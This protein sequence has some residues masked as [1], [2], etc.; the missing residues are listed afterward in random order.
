MAR[1]AVGTEPPVPR[2]TSERSIAAYGIHDPSPS[3]DDRLRWRRGAREGSAGTIGRGASATA[4]GCR[5]VPRLP[6]APRERESAPWGCHA[7]RAREADHAELEAARFAARTAGGS[8]GEVTH[9][10]HPR[11]RAVAGGRL[12]CTWTV[13]F[14]SGCLSSFVRC[15]PPRLLV[16]GASVTWWRQRIAPRCPGLSQCI[17][18][19]GPVLTTR[20]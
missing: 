12:R 14:R 15:P 5:S 17:P 20:L 2:N 4:Q 8:L 3:S 13:P 16:G 10:A 18:A 1:R 19:P 9:E 7:L 11:D 6:F